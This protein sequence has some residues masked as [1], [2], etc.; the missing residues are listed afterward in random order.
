[1]WTPESR[2]KEERQRFLWG[3]EESTL[4]ENKKEGEYEEEQKG[5]T[6]NESKESEDRAKS[7]EHPL[8]ESKDGGKAKRCGAP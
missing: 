5:H 3:E 1:M 8:L 4:V 2:K 7:F 6:P